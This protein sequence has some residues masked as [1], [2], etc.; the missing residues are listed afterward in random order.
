MSGLIG[1]FKSMVVEKGRK[2]VRERFGSTPVSFKVM[3]TRFRQ[4]LDNHNRA[5]EIIADMGA[6]LGGE[7]IFDI[8]YIKSAYEELHNRL[9]AS[10]SDFHVLTRNK[11]ARLDNV[12]N[13][14]D[15]EIRRLVYDETSSF[16]ETVVFYDDITWSMVREVGGKN[17]HLADLKNNLGLNVP[18]A[19]AVTTHA[20][21]EFIKHNGIKGKIAEL[22]QGGIITE[23]ALRDIRDSVMDGTIPPALENTFGDALTG[24][25]TKCKGN[26]SLA[27]RSSAEEEDGRY[28]FAGQFETVLNVPPDIKAVA[29][30]YKRVIASLFTDKAVA[31]LEQS[32]HDIRSMKMAVGCMLMVDAAASGVMYSSDPDLKEDAVLINAA[33]G[34]GPSIVEGRTDADIYTISK[35]AHPETTV[36]KI[37]KKDS[38]VISREGG[39]ISTVKVPAE[40]EM[41]SALTNEQTVELA[42]QALRIEHY[43]RKPQDIEWAIDRGGRV[44]ILQSRPLRTTVNSAVRPAAVLSSPEAHILMRAPGTAVQ[45]GAGAGRTFI[46]RHMDELGSFPKGAVLIARNDSSDFI[47]V[48][49]YASAIITDIGTPASHMASL[50]REFR[51]PAI[52]NV[53]N[54]SRILKHGQQITVDI[55][56]E[57]AVTIYEGVVKDILE[58][59]NR[60]VSM[61]M[62]DI[63]EFRKK[64]YVLRYI[65]PLNLID[66]MLDTFS[67]EGCKT[68]HD[69]LRFIHEKSVAEL[70]EGTRHGLRKQA[71]VKLDLPIPAGI[72]AVDI[73]G[74][75]D[76]GEKR[77]G[78]G[79][80]TFEHISS[81][82]LRAVLKG[83]MHPGVWHSDAVSLKA[84][85][86]LSSMM[87]MPDIT[88]ENYMENNIAVISREYVNLSLRFGY[89][90]NMLDCYCS[91]NTRNNHLYFRFT[92]GATDMVKRSRRIQ[93]IAVI[94]KEYGFNIKIKG[95]LI[96]GRLS[97]IRQDEMELVLDRIGRLIAYT[98]QLDA[99]L[100]DD[101]RIERYAHNFLEGKY[102]L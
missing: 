72:M 45:K 49:P 62:E 61:S 68:M 42:D 89:H 56:D 66:P 74:G 5:I 18:A 47:R 4:V 93:L 71:A 88:S 28:S 55:G 37:G 100:H 67:P 76:I 46:L 69:I 21:D 26:C 65:S 11:Y 92:G 40:M 36:R 33:W 32:G 87:R 75:L 35:A 95:D 44:F 17:A 6:K 50:C 86:F 97:N 80:V 59:A 19:F 20:F 43:F 13:R 25:R 101:G 39:G 102:E 7:Y 14:I 79:K 23:T 63:Y 91:E 12:F 38:M 85:D 83:M 96:I 54:A 2:I 58:D 1:L 10:L 34:L 41:R 27:V 16:N 78:D 90:F 15:R 77:D 81:V 70:V 99:L 84:Q 29:G 8:N 31:Y 52:V 22:G 82:P 53:G 98:R 64:R 57:G 9:S 24:V 3:F 30:A 48:M 60:K 73:G 94:L 51:V